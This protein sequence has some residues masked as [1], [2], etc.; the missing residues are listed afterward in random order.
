MNT[1]TGEGIEAAIDCGTRGQL[2]VT[3][4]S[5]S[6]L[7]SLRKELDDIDARL[8][9][10]IRDRIAV[11]SRVALVKREFDIPMMQPGRVGLVQE[12][13]RE[14]ARAHELSEDF[15]ASVYDLLIAE[16]CRVEDLIIDGDSPVG[17]RGT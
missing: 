8:L 2:H 14:F 9:D 16:A 15:L 11:C 7:S 17:N 10:M 13:A 6:Q 1:P 5:D 12:R 4:E 3:D